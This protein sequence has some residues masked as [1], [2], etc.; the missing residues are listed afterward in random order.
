MF[1]NSRRAS[2]TRKMNKKR[3]VFTKH[4]AEKLLERNVP[5]NRIR[6]MVEKAVRI[7]DKV[8]GATLRIY[9]EAT[10]N[11]YTVVTAEGDGQIT[12]ITCYESSVWQIEAYKKVKKDERAKML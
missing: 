2:K 4:A 7:E 6:Q 12:V 9:K 3:L 10:G 8:S 5:V 11:F 1:I